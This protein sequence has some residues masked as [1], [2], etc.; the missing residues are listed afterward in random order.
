MMIKV[1]GKENCGACMM[2]KK[3]LTRKGVDFEYVHLDELDA[4]EREV[5]LKMA[6]KQGMRS[7]PLI[8]KDGKL[9]TLQEV[10]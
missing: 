5:V 3:V 2:A 8:V 7:M 10:L 4:E 6:D 1:I 9:V